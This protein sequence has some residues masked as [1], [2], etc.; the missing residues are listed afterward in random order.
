MPQVNMKIIDSRQR[1]EA[2]VKASSQKI[3]AEPNGQLSA[4]YFFGSSGC[5]LSFSSPASCA[6]R[7][8]F[9]CLLAVLVIHLVS[10]ASHTSAE[11]R[12]SS[13]RLS[14]PWPL[15]TPLDSLLLGK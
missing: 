7:R 5:A 12:N 11:V 6:P 2:T 14:C 8:S 9:W 10:G 3:R 13:P 1:E 15:P 4:S